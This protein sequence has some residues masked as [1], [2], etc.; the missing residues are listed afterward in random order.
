MYEGWVAKDTLPNR[1]IFYNTDVCTTPKLT[2]WKSFLVTESL[3]VAGNG[4][5]TVIQ[6]E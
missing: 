4:S 6:Q 3:H 5:I 2:K 1:W